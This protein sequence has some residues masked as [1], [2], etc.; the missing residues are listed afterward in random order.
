MR[1]LVAMSGGIDSTAAALILKEQGHDVVGCTFKTRYTRD[2]SL[3]AASDLACELGVKHYIIDYSDYFDAEVV[4]RFRGEYLAGRTPNPCVI[5]N[6]KIK[7]GLLLKE[8]DNVGCERIA[9]G[10]YARIVNEREQ[11]FLERA[12]DTTK[13]QTYF[14]WQLSNE[15]LSRVSFPL[16]DKT[17]EQ[18]RKY[19]AQK[20]YLGLSSKGE[21]QDICFIENDYREFLNL[22]PQPGNYVDKAGKII[23]RHCGYTNYTIGQRKGLGIALGTPA[24]VGRIDSQ[25]NEV[26]LTDHDALYTNEVHLRDIIFRGDG[27]QPVMAQIRFRSQP[28]EAIVKVFQS[29]DEETLHGIVQFK[30]PVWAVTPG[31][32]C[33][34]YQNNKLVGGG[35]IE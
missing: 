22:P 7:F 2:E 31:Q 35:I 33:V 6:R 1:V 17:K 10:H 3:I 29:S 18:V 8:A 32:S 23:G 12:E 27:S 25:Q 28:Q 34:F 19:L 24:F 5:C 11:F 15:Q 20:G 4:T 14:L 13:D 26:L 30:C 16:G 9:T 21:S